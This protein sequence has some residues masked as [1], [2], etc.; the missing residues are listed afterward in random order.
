MYVTN[1]RNFTI[2]VA[3]WETFIDQLNADALAEKSAFSAVVVVCNALEVP[4]ELKTFVGSRFLF[5]FDLSVVADFIAQ[6]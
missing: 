4:F 2:E 3:L 5:D 1:D 6:Y